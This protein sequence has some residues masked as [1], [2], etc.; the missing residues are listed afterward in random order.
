MHMSQISLPSVALTVT[1]L[2]HGT[3]AVTTVP[4][5]SQISD[6]QP[7]APTAT[8]S[9]ASESWS[10]AASE[11]TS[12]TA[13]YE[14]PFTIYTTQT[15]SLGVITGMP[16]VWTSQPSQPPLV[17]SQPVSP[18]LPT[19]SGYYYNTTSSSMPTSSALVGTASSMMTSFTTTGSSSSGISPTFA[20][21]T[22]AAASS[23]V[24]GAAF[25][26]VAAGLVFSLL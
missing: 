15:N 26:L 16:S 1:L 4:A 6:G 23:R 7:Q 12:G 21:A 14:N 25:G 19:Y 11:W 17:T 22:G 9:A 20:Q 18:T 2:L 3:A 13:S 8:W 24:V 5:I 10:S